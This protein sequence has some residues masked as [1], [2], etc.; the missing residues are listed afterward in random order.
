MMKYFFGLLFL[1]LIVL[2]EVSVLPFFPVFGVQPNLLLVFLLALQ[3]LGLS[4]ESYYG[5][6]LGGILFDLLMGNLFGLSSL[7]LLLLMGAAGLVRRFAEGSLLVLLLLTFVV[8]VVFR[9]IQ[10]FPTFNPAILLKGGLVDVGVMVVV[11]P[12]LR[13]VLKSL[14]ARREIEVGV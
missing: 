4:Q 14:F 11:Y 13:Y 7:V 5:A 10:A 9:I 12:V 8:S 1:I 6:F 3:F 2:F